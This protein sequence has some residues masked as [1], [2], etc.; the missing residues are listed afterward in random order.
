MHSAIQQFR[1]NMLRARE[2]GKL[3]AAVGKIITP[4]IDV[5]DMWRAQVVLGV[6]ALDHFVHEMARL[7]MIETAKGTR[8]KT[9]AFLRFELPLDAVDLGLA[10]NAHELWLGEAVREKHGCYNPHCLLRIISPM[11]EAVKACG[12]VDTTDLD[13]LLSTGEPDAGFAD[14]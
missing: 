5:S 2:L 9:D 13:Q 4:A 11:A 1:E 7:G 10:G 6:S 12:P 8:P 14:E 3:A